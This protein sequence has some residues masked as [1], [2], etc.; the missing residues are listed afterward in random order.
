MN[1]KL[2]VSSVAG[3]RQLRARSLPAMRQGSKKMNGDAELARLG[4]YTIKP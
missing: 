4:A 3:R 1:W 2:L